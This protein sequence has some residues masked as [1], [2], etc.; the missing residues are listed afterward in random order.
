MNRFE[1]KTIIREEIRKCLHEKT[2]DEI[3]ADKKTVDAEIAAAKLRIKVAQANLKT[4]KDRLSALMK[5]KSE[6]AMQ[7][8][9]TE[10][11]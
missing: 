7:T 2:Q 1:L 6:V 5:K 11:K 10:E 3:D 4:A 8:A 9:S